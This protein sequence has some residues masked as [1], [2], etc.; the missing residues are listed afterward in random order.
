MNLFQTLLFFLALSAGHSPA[1]ASSSGPMTP[2]EQ[3][4]LV[5]TYCTGCH[6]DSVSMG[7]LSFEHFDPVR[8]D[9]A[10]AGM[11]AAEIQNGA[12]AAAGIAKPDPFVIATFSAALAARAGAAE[13]STGGWS[14]RSISDLRPP[15]ASDGSG[16]LP[17]PKPMVTASMQ[18][19]TE[20]D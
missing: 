8:L 7:G 19:G 4:A 2:G 11:M 5:K 15:K 6:S 20:F 14:I 3:A 1:Q 13:S 10:V 17:P 9:P 16:Y 18:A 12:M